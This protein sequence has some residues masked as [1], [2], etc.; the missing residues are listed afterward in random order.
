MNTTDNLQKIDVE[1]AN[2]TWEKF[3]ELH[4]QEMERIKHLN[5]TQLSSIG[6]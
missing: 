4:E 2:E 3:Y 5:R 6:L 1:R